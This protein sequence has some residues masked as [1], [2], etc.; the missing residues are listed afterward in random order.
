M[1][2]FLVSVG[3]MRT[4]TPGRAPVTVPELACPFSMVINSVPLIIPS[5]TSSPELGPLYTGAG[6]LKGAGAAGGAIRR[7]RASRCCRR[8]DSP[9]L[10]FAFAL[11]LILCKLATTL[12]DLSLLLFLF[13][14]EFREGSLLRFSLLLPLCQILLMSLFLLS[15]LLL[16]LF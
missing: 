2:T 4:A 16:Y 6:G 12:V 7:R 3:W 9:G 14:L 10:R 5:H 15:G 13:R 1:L 11:R 8:G